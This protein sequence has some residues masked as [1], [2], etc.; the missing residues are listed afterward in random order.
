MALS[1]HAAV[2]AFD[3]PVVVL[4]EASLAT[5]VALALSG[6]VLP[7]GLWIAW[8]AS[9]DTGPFAGSPGI[10]LALAALA[11]S[12]LL[13][14][15]VALAAGTVHARLL[16]G[17]REVDRARWSFR[18]SRRLAVTVGTRALEAEI[19]LGPE[20][21]VQFYVD[22]ALLATVPVV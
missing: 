22:G 21:E 11:A 17:N 18:P 15:A 12:V 14:G 4:I 19:S 8:L 3:A 13:V 2:V 5:R 10:S 20:R 9:D 6:G 1:G 7:L 16:V